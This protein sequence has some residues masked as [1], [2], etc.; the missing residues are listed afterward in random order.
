MRSKLLKR[1]CGTHTHP[2]CF[3]FPPKYLLSIPFIRSIF[4]RHLR[5]FQWVWKRRK[6][7]TSTSQH[8]RQKFQEKFEIEIVLGTKVMY[9]SRTTYI[10]LFP[11]RTS[12]SRS[13]P[14]PL[15]S[16]E[17]Y[18]RDLEAGGHVLW[19]LIISIVFISIFISY[20]SFFLNSLY[21]PVSYLS[22]SF[23]SFSP[24][25]VKHPFFHF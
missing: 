20:P 1:K 18:H 17:P 23:L 21:T 10:P 15:P 11:S 7:E 5:E 4:H 8:P 3:C 24:F 16:S 9:S 12:K 22:A 25:L 14:S 19:F 13:I 6:R 2:F